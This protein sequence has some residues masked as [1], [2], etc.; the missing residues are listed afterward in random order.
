MQEEQLCIKAEE[1]IIEKNASG[2]DIAVKIWKDLKK[3]A[4]HENKSDVFNG[5]MKKIWEKYSRL[6]GLKLSIVQH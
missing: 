3:L 2:Y 4:S 6:S 1:H 5:K